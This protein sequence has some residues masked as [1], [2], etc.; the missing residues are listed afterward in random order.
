M[1][2]PPDLQKVFMDVSG[3][4][5]E[6]RKWNDADNTA[7]FSFI[8][9][10]IDDIAA[11]HGRYHAITT[12]EIIQ[13]V[14]FAASPEDRALFAT[15]IGNGAQHSANCYAYAANDDG[16]PAAMVSHPGFYS[17]GSFMDQNAGSDTDAV[18]KGMESDGFT[19][20]D[21]LPSRPSKDFY[22]VALAFDTATPDHDFHFYRRDRDGTWSH[23]IAWNRISNRDASGAV[24]RNLEAA[25]RR[26]RGEHN[27]TDLR[28]YFY[29]PREGLKV[30]LP[31]EAREKI[32]QYQNEN[33]SRL[34]E[35]LQ[36]SGLEVFFQ[37][38]NLPAP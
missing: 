6:P 33:S 32:R 24:I 11:F 35:Y 5:Y 31:P 15:I 10:H 2:A 19:P 16:N 23:K 9:G 22:L 3:L 27:Y 18:I 8:R 12:P 28:G 21:R 25:D 38:F 20:L 36:S 29:A 30:G 14:N 17:T 34:H 13:Y 26:G 37:K 7:F 1:A 4:P